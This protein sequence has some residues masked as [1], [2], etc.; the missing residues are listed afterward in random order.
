[1][2]AKQKEK[3]DKVASTALITGGIVAVIVAILMFVFLTPLLRFMGA[4]F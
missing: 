4:S 3:A 2:G 1:L